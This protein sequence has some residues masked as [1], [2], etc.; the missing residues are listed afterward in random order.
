MKSATARLPIRNRP[1]HILI[2]AELY[3]ILSMH[4]WR[5]PGGRYP[6]LPR[7]FTYQPDESGRAKAIF[8]ARALTHAGENEFPQHLN[9]DRLDCRRAN[10]RLA[11]TRGEAG[12]SK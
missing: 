7:P 9:G 10:L 5:V 1:W 2:D 11:A 6:Q 12:K 3:P 8:L 4:T